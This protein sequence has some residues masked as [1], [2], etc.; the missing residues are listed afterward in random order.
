MS[1]LDQIQACL[2]GYLDED[3]CNEIFL[4]TGM[5]AELEAVNLYETM[6]MSTSN[7]K[8]KNILLSISEEEKVHVGEFQHLLK[9]L[10]HEY[11][12][13]L[14]TGASEVVEKVGK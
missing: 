14:E 12:V 6:A 10:D 8:I 3:T 1:F 7:K 13:A 9:K 4:R 2:H 11:A 5:M